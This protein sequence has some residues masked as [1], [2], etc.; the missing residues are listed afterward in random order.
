MLFKKGDF[1]IIL[2]H[3]QHVSESI[4]HFMI[5]FF[6]SKKRGKASTYVCRFFITIQLPNAKS[7]FM[8]NKTVFVVYFVCFF[9]DIFDTF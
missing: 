2:Y 8:Q 7:I 3:F 6:K 1:N 5:Y 4:N 9:S